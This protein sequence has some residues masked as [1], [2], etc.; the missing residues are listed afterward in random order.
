[1]V[2]LP[3]EKKL[4]DAIMGV[5]L[6]VRWTTHV[7]EFRKKLKDNPRGCL[8]RYYS[9]LEYRRR[10]DALRSA[11]AAVHFKE[12]PHVYGDK[13]PEMIERCQKQ[14]K[15]SMHQAWQYASIQ[16]LVLS[17]PLP[18]SV[19]EYVPFHCGDQDAAIG[20]DM[21]A[22][23]FEIRGPLQMVGCSYEGVATM[24]EVKGLVMC[25]IR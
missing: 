21:N 23:N 3:S 18:Q 12:N 24:D 2:K 10:D 16:L 25:W 5:W 15:E 20:Q 8:A 4:K 13:T 7:D 9:G 1:M 22:K 11:K 17:E 19:L 14:A 6:E